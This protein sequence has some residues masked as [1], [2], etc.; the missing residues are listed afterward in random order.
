MYARNIPSTKPGAHLAYSGKLHGTEIPITQ[1]KT[2]PL[3]YIRKVMRTSTMGDALPV[4]RRTSIF[5]VWPTLGRVPMSEYSLA[6]CVN[7]FR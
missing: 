5:G 3:V 7:Y 2:L 6:F 1:S 4:I